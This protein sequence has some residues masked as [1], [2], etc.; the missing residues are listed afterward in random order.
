M[1]AYWTAYKRWTSTVEHETAVHQSGGDWRSAR[2]KTREAYS[3]WSN[4]YHRISG[5]YPT[6][7]ESPI[8]P[9]Q[10]PAYGT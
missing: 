5:A 3:E 10:H 9:R 2:E 1:D 6:V 7:F 4:A 8:D